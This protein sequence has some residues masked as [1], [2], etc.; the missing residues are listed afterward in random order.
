MVSLQ[1]ELT[2]EDMIEIFSMEKIP[3]VLHEVY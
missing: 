3:L 1:K 2:Q